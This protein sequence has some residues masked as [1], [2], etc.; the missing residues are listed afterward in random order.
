MKRLP[1]GPLFGPASPLPGTLNVAPSSTPAGMVIETVL[2]RLTAPPAPASRARVGDLDPFAVA[3]GA[4][5]R[6]HELA[7]DGL[8]DTADLATAAADA[9]FSGR[10]PVFHA[11]AVAVLAV[12]QADDF[13]I[14]LGAEDGLF[15]GEIDG[16]LQIGAALRGVPAAGG[17]AGGASEEVLE[18]VAEGRSAEATEWIAA[19]H[20]V[21]G[22]VAEPI[23]R[24]PPVRIGQDFVGFVDLFEALFGVVFRVDIGVVF[25]GK[26]AVG[27]LD[28]IGGRSARHAENLVVVAFFGHRIHLSR[29]GKRRSR[30]RSVRSGS[31]TYVA[32]EDALEVYRAG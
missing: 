8:L 25:A 23:V 15:E 21:R 4:G 30:R 18:E 6:G 14:A 20:A 22:S 3:G 10:L 24:R 1:A 31:G 26:G 17:A 11:G 16:L 2:V 32:V 29:Q 12:F 9:T 13:D 5:C 19:A 7:Q 27:P 28:L